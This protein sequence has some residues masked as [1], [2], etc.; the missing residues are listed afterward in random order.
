[1]PL[2]HALGDPILH[3]PRLADPAGAIVACLLAMAFVT[4]VALAIHALIRRS[5]D[6]RSRSAASVSTATEL[7]GI[8]LTETIESSAATIPDDEPDGGLP[9]L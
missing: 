4:F 8:S 3:L 9:A 6:A 7:Q 1:M 5:E 2:H